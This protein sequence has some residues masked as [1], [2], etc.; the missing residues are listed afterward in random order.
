MPCRA[1]LSPLLAIFTIGMFLPD[2]RYF[3]EGR[4][5]LERASRT[6]TSEMLSHNRSSWRSA[7]RTPPLL[8]SP[9]S[10]GRV[11][12]GLMGASQSPKTPPGW[13][14]MQPARPIHRSSHQRLKIP[15][16]EEGDLPSDTL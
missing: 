9:A 2:A 13:R 1:W 5:D 10:P 4:P 15:S 8:D 3:H 16:V 12:P 6:L 11:L 14:E 7:V